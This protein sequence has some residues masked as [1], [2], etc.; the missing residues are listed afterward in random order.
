MRRGIRFA[1]WPPSGLRQSRQHSAALERGRAAGSL[2]SSCLRGTN[3]RGRLLPRRSDDPHRRRHRMLRIRELETGKIVG[4]EGVTPHPVPGNF[5]PT[6]STCFHGRT[7]VRCGCGTV[8]AADTLQSFDSRADTIRKAWHLDSGRQVLTW[9]KN[10]R[11]G[12]GVSRLG[13]GVWAKAPG[14]RRRSDDRSGMERGP[15]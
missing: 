5:R 10:G 9:G 7:T 11:K 15:W 2:D 6:E 13:R 3:R 1:R 4:L 14:D 8:S 12:P